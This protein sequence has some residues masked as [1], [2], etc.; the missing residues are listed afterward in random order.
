MNTQGTSP[1]RS[2]PLGLT[3]SIV[4]QLI[5]ALWA[6]H[7]VCQELA[8][9][10]KLE[11]ESYV[12]ALA[13]SPDGTM[14]AAGC[15]DGVRLW[16]MAGRKSVL[17]PAG[18]QRVTGICFSPDGTLLAAGE[19]CKP[20]ARES[21]YF[22]RL[23]LWETGSG[24]LRKRRRQESPI[25]SLAFSPD[26]KIVAFGD[27]DGGVGLWHVADN[28][29]DRLEF[30]DPVSIASV[31]FSPDGKTLAAGTN[32]PEPDFIPLQG[33]NGTP[34]PLPGRPVGEDGTILVWDL[35]TRK[36]ACALSEES[37]EG[38][39]T[40][41]FS[42][43]GTTLASSHEDGKI[44][45]WDVPSGKLLRSIEAH[46]VPS[47]SLSLALSP[48]GKLLASG[49][50]SEPVLRL[51][52]VA[53]GRPLC[54]A[55]A[56]GARVSAVAFSPDGQLVATAA[57]GGSDEF[58]RLW[59]PT[60]YNAGDDG[61]VAPKASVD[62]KYSHLLRKIAVPEDR[63]FYGEFYDWGYWS[64]TSWQGHTDLPPGYWVYVFPHWY[65]WRDRQD[66]QQ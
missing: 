6:S 57:G 47:W 34:I 19:Y 42:P 9:E 32:P 20:P 37:C 30:D 46:P 35:A 43:D 58:V 1:Q 40:L 62:D 21:R 4:L 63:G 59:K 29:L 49:A 14:L 39:S 26:G 13:F 7:G 18:G 5:G 33:A 28:R 52:D 41:A 44:R 53:T 56:G 48:S 17:D 2:V 11:G 38:V 27:H 25:E 15:D 10:G 66:E 3:S 24:R 8:S 60:G 22:G 50:Y 16:E 54:S 36:R 31:A 23:S 45:F 61:K 65:I 64:G 55:D 51:W 12:F